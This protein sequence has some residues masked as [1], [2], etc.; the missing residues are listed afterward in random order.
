ME[1]PKVGVAILDNELKVV[2]IS[3][4]HRV[5]NHTY[6]SGITLNY[7]ESYD[8]VKD[9]PILI[10]NWQLLAVLPEQFRV[11]EIYNQSGVE[12]YQLHCKIC[13]EAMIIK[14]ASYLVGLKGIEC[15]CG[16]RR[17]G[18][19]RIQFLEELEE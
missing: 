4:S 19:S 16:Y 10:D 2:S 17:I 14:N 13:S 8:T 3:N 6:H 1:N 18:T 12:C 15:S 7:S 9:C 5:G 11:I